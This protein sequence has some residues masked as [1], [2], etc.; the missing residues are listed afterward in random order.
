[1]KYRKGYKYQLVDTIYQQMPFKPDEDIETQFIDFRKNGLLIVKSGYAWD[2][3]SG[4]TIDTDNFM[5]PSLVHDAIYQ[6]I[7]YKYLPVAFR[8]SADKML[9]QMCLDRGM[10]KIRAWYVYKGVSSYAQFAADPR[11]IKKVYEVS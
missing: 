4:P 9:K 5:T 1:M 3:P 2:G 6:L 7:R 8:I 10:S 11:N